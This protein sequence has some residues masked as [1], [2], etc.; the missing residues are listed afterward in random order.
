MT[1]ESEA[2]WIQ[3]CIDKARDAGDFLE[4]C[5]PGY[6]NNE[7]RSGNRNAQDGFY[8]GGS[9]EFFHIL[10]QWRDEGSLD[11]LRLKQSES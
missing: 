8:G 3:Q 7:G 4:N 1:Q 10:Q 11:G 2:S 6:Y 9:I 5:T